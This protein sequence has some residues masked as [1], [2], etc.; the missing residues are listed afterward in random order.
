VIRFCYFLCRHVSNLFLIDFFFF[1][2][3]NRYQVGALVLVPII[4]IFGRFFIPA[5]Q[6]D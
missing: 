6:E 2:N 5:I 3:D 4:T 1:I